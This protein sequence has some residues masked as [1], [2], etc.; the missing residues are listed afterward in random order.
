MNGE[1][2]HCTITVTGRSWS[3]RMEDRFQQKPAL[4]R[5]SAGTDSCYIFRAP[6]S[7]V[8]SNP[9][10][11]KPRIVSI[12]PYH[13]GKK[14]LELI[15]QHKTRAFYKLLDR[16]RGAVG[17]I[18]YFNAIASRETHIRD[19]YS[20]ALHW[21]TSDLIGMMILDACFII[22]L[23]RAHTCENPE[24]ADDPVFFTP[25]IVSS[26]MID[27]L[28]IE[29]Q[30][31][32]FVL[33]EI[34]AKSKSP[35][36]ANR[37]LKEI[38]LRFFNR[39]LQWPDE[40]LR[41]HYTV[42]N[43]THLLDLFRLCLVGHLNIESPPPVD[44]E[45]LQLMPSTNHL[46]LAGIK[47]EPRKSKNLIDVVFDDG[48]LR[49]PPFTIDLFTSSFFLNCVAYEQCCHYCSKHISSYVV[50]MRC[51]M[52]TAADAVFLS[53]CGV[54]K[55][56]LGADE[57]VA[58]FFSDLTKD[59]QFDIKLS[60]LAEVFGKVTRYRR[61]KWRMRWAGIKREYF[62]SPWSFISAAAAF[63]LLVLT[64]IQAFFTV[65]PYYHPKK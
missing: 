1:S 61:N 11:Y 50:F 14:R 27:L 31:P 21:N 32:F 34:Y 43:I 20:E 36:D 29:N 4:L 58:R 10:A 12:G 18:D 15:E 30:I 3:S 25:W 28:L 64:V 33:Q 65:Y 38:A 60:Y 59:V 55:N 19:R 37:S 22:E 35:S 24:D 2:N 7:Q 26:L 40:H 39:A 44:K 49:I 45:L 23:F 47:F 53:Q 42:S 5:L 56:L 57:E 63:I 6:K 51:L 16:T 41:K 8:E 9:N 54:I 13:H 62:G 46:L 17:P 48:V 52:G